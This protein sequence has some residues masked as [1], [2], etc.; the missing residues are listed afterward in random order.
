MVKCKNMNK[1]IDLKFIDRTR[2]GVGL[3]NCN[4]VEECYHMNVISELHWWP[5][6]L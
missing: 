4:A 5:L 2:G 6:R 1:F 3:S